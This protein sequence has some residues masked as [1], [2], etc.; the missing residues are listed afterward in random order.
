[1]G[2]NSFYLTVILIMVS[3]TRLN[4]YSHSLQNCSI[5]SIM[6]KKQ[7]LIIWILMYVVSLYHVTVIHFGKNCK[8]YIHVCVYLYRSASSWIFHK[9]IRNSIKT[10]FVELLTALHFTTE[11]SSNVLMI[12]NTNWQPYHLFFDSA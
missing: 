2:K 4:K 10:W 7:T 8:H 1:M 5:F 11:Y 3:K 9:Q 6:C 12:L